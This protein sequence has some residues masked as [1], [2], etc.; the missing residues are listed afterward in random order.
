MPDCPDKECK[1]NIEKQ[2]NG[3]AKTLYGSEGI[4]GLVSK[5]NDKVSRSWLATTTISMLG[6]LVVIVIAL[7]GGYAERAKNIKENEKSISVIQEQLSD[8]DKDLDEIKKKQDRMILKQIDPIELI[9]EIKKVI[10]ESNNG[11]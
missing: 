6:I 4:T 5:V 10:D 9:K 11:E 8:I 3:H 2:I 7:Q 1:K